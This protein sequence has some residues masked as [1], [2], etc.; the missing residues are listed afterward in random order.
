MFD[1]LRC[2]E[3]DMGVKPAGGKDLTFT[4]NDV[5]ARS[6]ND[7]YARLNIGIARFA[8]GVDTAILQADI[9]LHNAPMVNDQGIGDH[10][11][12]RT[13]PVR[14]LTLA[15]TIANDLAAAKF[16]LL[17]IDR[18]IFLDFNHEGRIG[19]TNAVACGG[20]EH[21]RIG[22]AGQGR[23]HRHLQQH[24]D[25]SCKHV[26]KKHKARFIASC[27]WKSTKERRRTM[28]SSGHSSQL[29]DHEAMRHHTTARAF[30]SGGAFCPDHNARGGRFLPETAFAGHRACRFQPRYQGPND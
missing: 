8:D 6:D 16:D 5:R 28:Q 29:R 1:L 2:N 20:T 9:R 27:V 18:E 11:I 14:D 7:R 12:N 13:V 24:N 3:M 30:K 19:K 10:G 15:H 23:S 26:R 4:R 25:W 22:G 17:A 21:I